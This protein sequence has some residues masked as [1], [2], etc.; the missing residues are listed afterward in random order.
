MISASL[1]RFGFLTLPNYSMIACANAIE[2]LRMANRLTGRRDYDWTIL[3]LDG[4]PAAASNG[5]SLG[6]TLAL[7]AAEGLDVVFVCGGVDV[8]L[9]VGQPVKAALRRLAR[10]GLA[11]GALC[12]G[13]FAL[14]EAR[15]LKGYRCAIHWE[16]LSSIREE[17]PDIDFVQDLYAIDRDRLTCT[18]GIAPLDMMLHLIGGRLGGEVASQISRQFI[19]DRSRA[20]EERQPSLAGTPAVAGHPALEQAVR[21]MEARIDAPLPISAVARQAGV[22]PR[23]LERLFRGR[24]GQTPVAFALSL[25]LERA[26]NLLRQT[27]LP[28]TSIAMAC[29]FNSAAHF[30]VAYRQRF[31]RSPRQES[32]PLQ[33]AG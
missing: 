18:G 13:T 16:N 12:T 19:L 21:L 10:Q 15:L 8:R 9:A 33:G 14:A 23:Q 5:L 22:S 29:G 2:P 32:E 6:P 1:R 11:L 24:L 26:R 30:A 27:S 28:V 4:A 7:Q 25:R 20:G 3:T 31:G 17:F